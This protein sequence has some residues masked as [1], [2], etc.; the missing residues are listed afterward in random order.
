MVGG[1]GVRLSSQSRVTQSELFVCL[2]VDAGS[3]V[4]KPALGQSGLQLSSGEAVVRIASAVEREWLPPELVTVATEVYFDEAAERV[5]ARRQVRWEDLVLEESPAALPQD[6]SV[7][8]MLAEGALRNWERIHPADDSPASRFVTR[9]RCLRDWLPELNFPA[10]D[11]AQ[12]QSLLPVLC[13]GRRSLAELKEASWLE[14]VHAELT[15]TQ[16]Q[17]VEREA[18]ERILVPSGSRI[19]L[20]YEAGRPPVLAVRIQEIFGWRETPRIARGRVRV[21]LHLLAPSHRPQQITDDLVSFWANAYP[22][23]RSELRRRY[24]KHAWPDNPLTAV[25]AQKG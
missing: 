22:Q 16:W 25:A 11:E 19:A 21:L 24:P 3:G 4:G 2:D 7:A 23:I 8:R 9:V 18:P 13:V 14:A 10:F 17:A 20:Q 1:Y 15:A 12:W 6:D 5:Q